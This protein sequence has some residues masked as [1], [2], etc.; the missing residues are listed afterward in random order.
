[1]SRS[2]SFSTPAIVLKRTSVG[3][4]DRVVTLLTQKKG[5]IVSVAKGVRKLK[6]SKRAFLEPGNLIKAFFIE[7][8]SMPL[9]TQATLI[10]DF[11]AAKINLSKIRQLAQVLEI[12]DKLFVEEEDVANFDQVVKALELL[13]KN[14][15][16]RSQIKTILME[17][18]SQLGF[19]DNG[20]T[21]KSLL[22]RVE[23]ITDRKMKSWEYLTV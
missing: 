2:R 7:T 21:K 18:I 14:G 4:S 16:H 1:V 19:E 9:L 11:S 17:I 12:V 22:E 20:S 23:Q 10:D 5:K 13:K 15:H 3:D 8:K 6:S